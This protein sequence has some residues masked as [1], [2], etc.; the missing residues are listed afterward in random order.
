MSRLTYAL[1]FIRTAGSPK[2]APAVASSISIAT[3]ITPDA[4]TVTIET[5]GQYETASLQVH[6]TF[7]QD[8][9]F[10]ETGTITFGDPT[11]NNLLH[12]STIG[13]G[14]LNPDLCTESPYTP[15]T[16]MWR[17]DE[18]EGFFAGATGAITSNFL[19]NKSTNEL[20]AYQFG[21]VNLP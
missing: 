21:V 16:V 17:I 10:T 11:G 1:Q 18:G 6:P 7:N 2:D 8:G 14:Y 12:F 3:V 4:V 5:L 9:S 15:G 20:I 19:I 13:L